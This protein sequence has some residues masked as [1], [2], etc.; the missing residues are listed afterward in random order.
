MSDKVNVRMMVARDNWSQVK[1]KAT[2]EG[3][4]VSAVV[5]AILDEYFAQNPR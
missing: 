4:K 2:R 1:A 5:E 3:K